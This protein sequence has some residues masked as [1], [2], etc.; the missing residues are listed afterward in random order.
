VLVVKTDS[1][2]NMEWN[3]TFAEKHIISLVETPEGNYAFAGQTI[4]YDNFVSDI[5]LGEIGDFNSNSESMS[6]STSAQ[7]YTALIPGGNSCGRFST[8]RARANLWALDRTKPDYVI[9]HEYV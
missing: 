8:L 3:Q 5:W 9:D 1:S 6:N 4:D 2:G 7:P